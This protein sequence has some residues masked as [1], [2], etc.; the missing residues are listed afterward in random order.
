[1]GGWYFS[2]NHSTA[3]FDGP[4][5]S[6]PPQLQALFRPQRSSTPSRIPQWSPGSPIKVSALS[7]LQASA[8]ALFLGILAFGGVFS[9]SLGLF[10]LRLWNRHQTHRNRPEIDTRHQKPWKSHQK[11]APEINT[12]THGNAGLTPNRPNRTRNRHQIFL[13]KRMRNH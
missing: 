3:V 9:L 10:L 7:R 4:C 5:P 2:P 11:I 6:S 8:P 12:Q 1:M 13:G